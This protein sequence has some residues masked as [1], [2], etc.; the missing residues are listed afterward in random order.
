MG[1]VKSIG[2]A[3]GAKA[4]NEEW[5]STDLSPTKIAKFRMSVCLDTTVK[6]EVTINSGTKFVTLNEDTALVADA[7]YTFDIAVRLDD[8]FNIRIPTAGGATI[9]ICRLDQIAD[10]G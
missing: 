10:E 6:V 1:D 9:V 7:L 4:Q 8:K 5:L 2:D 3:S